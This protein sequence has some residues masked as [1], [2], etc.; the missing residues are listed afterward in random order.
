MEI[1]QLEALRK[2]YNELKDVPGNE[3]RLNEIAFTLV[4]YGY[5]WNIVDDSFSEEEP[6]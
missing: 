1:C 6:A 3:R 4:M 5:C 2:A